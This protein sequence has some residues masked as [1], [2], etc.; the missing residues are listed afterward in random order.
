MGIVSPAPFLLAMGGLALFVTVVGGPRELQFF[1]AYPVPA[2]VGLL[3]G[4]ALGVAFVLARKRSVPPAL[5]AGLS[6]PPWL[7]A[8]FLSLRDMREMDQKV[9][10]FLHTQNGRHIIG[11]GLGEQTQVLALGLWL[12]AWLLLACALGGWWAARRAD[13]RRRRHV[14]R[15]LLYSAFVHFAFAQL[16]LGRAWTFMSSGTL[17]SEAARRWAA[18]GAEKFSSWKDGILVAMFL[19][20]LELL[21]QGYRSLKDSRALASLLAL[22]TVMA[23]SLGLE[24]VSWREGVRVATRYDVPYRP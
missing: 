11:T 12:S 1:D 8:L 6:L 17:D 7:T 9:S 3:S 15:L 19:L 22:A 13:E 2:T 23:L 10:G 16:M 5:F 21:V 18:L 4:V 20:V 14:P 24:F